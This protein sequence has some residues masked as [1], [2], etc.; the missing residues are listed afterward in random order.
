MEPF[1]N[2]LNAMTVN[3]IAVAIKSIYSSFDTQSFLLDINKSL[4]P[5]E[6]KARS[7][8]IKDRLTA[9][10][11]KDPQISFKIL[12]SALKKGNQDKVGLDGFK[13]WPLTQFISEHGLK[14]FE[15]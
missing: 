5:L 2:R 13:V 14:D 11:P 4:K 15:I 1:K 8:L 7:L 12:I 9:H 10:L 6:L 3:D